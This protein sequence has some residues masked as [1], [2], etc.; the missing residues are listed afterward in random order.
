MIS[1]DSLVSGTPSSGE[2]SSALIERDK[3]Q[4]LLTAAQSGDTAL[5]AEAVRCFEGQQIDDIKDGRGRNALHFA[6]TSGSLESCRYLLNE[7]QASA[8]CKAEEGRTCFGSFLSLLHV[9]L[10]SAAYGTV[11]YGQIPMNTA[12]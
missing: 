4:R 2:A 3:V 10:L 7:L 8:N 6:A 5:L 1:A 9:E 11:A 12:L